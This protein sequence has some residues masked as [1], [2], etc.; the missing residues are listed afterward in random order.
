MTWE[1]PE[2]PG[3]RTLTYG[4]Y[5]SAGGGPRMKIRIVNE[6]LAVIP[7]K[8]AILCYYMHTNEIG[9]SL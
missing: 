6:T 4:V 1:P 3:T 2:W 7:S 9:Q 5:T 8:I